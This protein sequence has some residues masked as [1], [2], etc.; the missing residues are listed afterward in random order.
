MERV[1]GALMGKKVLVYLDYVLIFAAMTDV[2]L[3]TLDQVF[4]LLIQET[5]K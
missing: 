3:Q 1:L 5:V 4:G 2:L